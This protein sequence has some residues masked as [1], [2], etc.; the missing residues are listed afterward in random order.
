MKC[1]ACTHIYVIG[2]AQSYSFHE[3]NRCIVH[4]EESEIPY[5]RLWHANTLSKNKNG[6]F[7]DSAIVTKNGVLAAHVS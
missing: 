7:F 4:G 3:R 2:V 6:I 1:L 5:L